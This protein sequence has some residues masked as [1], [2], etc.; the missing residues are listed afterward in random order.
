MKL[1]GS[2]YGT[3]TNDYVGDSPH[4]PALTQREVAKYANVSERSGTEW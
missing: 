2:L 3:F 1:V 4:R